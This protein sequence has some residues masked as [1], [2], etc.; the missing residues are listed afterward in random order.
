VSDGEEGTP[1]LNIR[2]VEVSRL[3]GPRRATGP[4]PVNTSCDEKQ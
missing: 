3:R 2:P 4:S 1:D